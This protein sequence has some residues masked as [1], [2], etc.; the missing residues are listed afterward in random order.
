ML[1]GVPAEIKA[2]E[3]RVGLTPAG[4]A[5]LVQRGHQVRVQAGAGQSAGYPDEAYE[6]AGVELVC[7]PES[8]F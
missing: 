3:R 8:V 1:I 7:G 5:S 2:W 6:A 4:A